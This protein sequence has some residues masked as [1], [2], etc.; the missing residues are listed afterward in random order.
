MQQRGDRGPT[1]GEVTVLAGQLGTPCSAGGCLG[2]EDDCPGHHD[3]GVAGSGGAP[4]EVDVVAEYRELRVEAAQF[5]QDR[6]A[7]Q[8]AGGVD[9]EDLADLV[10]LALVVI[11]PLEPGLLT[12]GAIGSASWW[13]RVWQY[14]YYSVVAGSF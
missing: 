13:D 9:G 2:V 4:A 14:V 12:T 3:G 1:L 5:G 8:H 11:P 6:A 10:V 7:H